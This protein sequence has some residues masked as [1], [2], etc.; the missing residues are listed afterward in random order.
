M[1]VERQ[2]TGSA[3][4]RWSG[5][6]AA[7]K[8]SPSA[9][10][11]P[12][13]RWGLFPPP[14]AAGGPGAPRRIGPYL[15]VGVATFGTVLLAFLTFWDVLVPESAGAGFLD[16]VGLGALAVV[17]GLFTMLPAILSARRQAA[18]SGRHRALRDRL[19]PTLYAGMEEVVGRWAELFLAG[20]QVD[21][22]VWVDPALAVELHVFLK[23]DG[24]Y[25]IVASSSDEAS[26]VR[27]LE[28]A[29]SEGMIHAV[30]RRNTAVVA[31]VHPDFS[32]KLFSR[33]GREIGAQP[34]LRP[35]NADKC[36]PDL[37]WVYATPIFD[38]RGS[39]P[40]S[41]RALGVLAV[42]GLLS[43]S[44]ELYFRAE[45]RR[46]ADAVAL[47]LAPYVSACNSLMESGRMQDDPDHE[48]WERD[49]S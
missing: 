44:N 42:D 19:A 14:A 13:R 34:P 45:F 9:A 32:A 47:Q 37:R 49:G 36:S 12:V 48:A 29:E 20:V 3:A 31:R 35:K 4:K 30:Y 17:T 8:P 43:T 21:R 7:E 46:L 6:A 26:N 2:V 38:Q 24:H 40:Y 1:R 41:N 39:H 28:L 10:R 25:R 16:L 23:I 33:N 22:K 18:E 15:G 5:H 27:R 11:L